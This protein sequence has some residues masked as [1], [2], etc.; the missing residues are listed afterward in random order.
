MNQLKAQFKNKFK[1]NK[2]VAE[3]Y[4]FMTFL[5]S[6]SLVIGLILY[7]YVIR[8]LGKE[9]YGIYIF[10]V[11]NIQLFQ[12]F[13]SF[14]FDMPALKKISLFP[15]HS[16]IK[17]RVVSEV[18]ISKLLLFPISLLIIA[19]ISV[20]VPFVQRHIALYYIVFSSQLVEILFPTWYFQGIQR[21]KFVT[22]TNLAVRLVT[23]PLIFIFIRSSDD[24][25]LYALVVSLL[26]LCGSIFA[27]FYL[28][29]K[30]KIRLQLCS[31]RQLK[32]T[33]RSALPFFWTVAFG[34][35]KKESVTFVIGTFF[36]MQSVALY[37]LASKLILIPRI[38]T[39]NING[40]L[41]PNVMQNISTERIKRIMRYETYISLIIIILVVVL[42]Y[43]AVL[44]LGGKTMLAAYPMAII[45]S[46]TIYTW[47]IAGS[48][49]NFVFIPQGRY[50][51]VANN[52]LWAM[53][54][55]LIMAF[56]SIVI[57]KSLI[58]IV[59]AFALSHVVEIIYCR[60]MISK[61]RMLE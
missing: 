51:L 25:L 19:V 50:S 27:F 5:A 26:P 58:M 9:A 29:I 2:K 36:S 21:M 18:F 32:S 48:Y 56:V 14:G 33:F 54:S 61:Y 4:F 34:T 59:I 6:S 35:V 47:L 52:Q 37:D 53:L 3:N 13:S 30:E 1:N 55:F 24:L 15:D 16:Q 41:F 49:I 20:F 22:Y 57:Y 38:I 10:I 39:S 46:I 45:L 12:V 60:Y 23:I 28:I 43:W 11:S 40:A 44:L 8:I 17:S 31:I 42:G 7:P